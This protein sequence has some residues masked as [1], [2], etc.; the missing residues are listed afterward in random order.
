MSARTLRRTFASPFVVTL[1]A[2]PGCMMQ[3]AP[4]RSQPSQMQP[5]QP[6]PPVTN[7]A[8]PPRPANDEPATSP[9]PAPPPTVI[10][11]PPRPQ[12]AQAATYERHWTVMRRGDKCEVYEDATCP[13]N[14]TCNPPPPRAYACT[15]EVTQDVPLKIVQYTG[16]TTCQVERAPMKCP[17]KVM[18]NPPPPQKVTCPQ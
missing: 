5:A 6:S 1:A 8:N 13:P 18:C 12:T 17:P 10:A 14:A 9:P 3:S 2:L 4:P 7:I 16:S 15:Q 11:N